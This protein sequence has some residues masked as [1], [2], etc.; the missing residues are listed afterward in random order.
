MLHDSSL[1]RLSITRKLY[2]EE[3]Y[4]KEFDAKIVSVEGQAVVLDQ[5][6]FYPRGGGVACDTGTLNASKVQE[7]TKADERILHTLECSSSLKPGDKVKGQVNW[8][9]RHAL[10][11]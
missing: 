4:S 10:M 7:T 11:K 3:P 1:G 2:W 8:E 9:R 5:T 6:L